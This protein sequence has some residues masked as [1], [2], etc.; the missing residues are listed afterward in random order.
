MNKT[1]LLI[2]H[3]GIGYLFT[4]AGF[5]IILGD[6]FQKFMAFNGYGHYKK[7]YVNSSGMPSKKT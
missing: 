2:K 5:L 1:L 3:Y 4:L 6:A 7:A